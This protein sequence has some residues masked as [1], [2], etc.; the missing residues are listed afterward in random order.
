MQLVSFKNFEEID[1]KFVDYSIVTNCSNI[2]QY[3]PLLVIFKKFQQLN[4]K[5]P[6]TDFIMSLSNPAYIQI[7]LRFE[8]STIIFCGDE[9]FFTKLK[10]LAI[11]YNTK[12]IYC[13][14]KPS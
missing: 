9:R 13:K 12:L 10:N 5:F 3:Y 14:K 4:K 11:K 2:E 8:F 6:N 7:A 1:E